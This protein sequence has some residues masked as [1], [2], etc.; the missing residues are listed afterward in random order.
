[1]T[2][3]GWFRG[4]CCEKPL[5]GVYSRFVTALPLEPFG[6][7]WNQF[8]VRFYIFWVYL[9]FEATADIEGTNR[10]HA[11]SNVVDGMSQRTLTVKWCICRQWTFAMWPSEHDF[12]R[13][14][15][16]ESSNN[17]HTHTHT[18]KNLNLKQL[19]GYRCCSAGWESL[20]VGIW[21][22]GRSRNLPQLEWWGLVTLRKPRF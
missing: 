17:C 4:P 15:A 18:L 3:I 10:P 20:L 8:L 13:R 9:I 6:T 2:D 14:L 7:I 21:S 16:A 22:A 1:M 5:Y 12:G 19:G 11:Q